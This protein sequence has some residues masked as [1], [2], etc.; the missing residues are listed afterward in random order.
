MSAWLASANAADTDFPL[1][2]LPYGA[3]AAPGGEVHLGVAIGDQIL[4]LRA[5]LA[6]SAFDG[7]PEPLRQACA[8][9]SLNRLMGLGGGLARGLRQRLTQMLRQGSAHAEAASR[10]LVP[11]TGTEMR[12]PV[13]IGDYTDFYASLHH[14]FNVGSLFRPESPLFPNY[15]HVPI[16]YHGRSSSVVVSPEPVRRPWG[17]WLGTKGGGAPPDFAPCRQLDYEVEVG[18]LVGCGN[19]LGEPVRL[20]QAEEHIFGLCL[21]ND[22]SAR[23]IQR[24]EYQPLGPFLGKN[25]ATSVSPWVVPLEALSAFR[26][27]APER[28]PG[29]PALLPDLD[30]P[31]DRRLGGL[32]MMVE[33]CL[34]SRAMREQELE[35]VRLS[36]ATLLDLYWTMGQ[37]LTH[38][39]SNGCNLRPGDLLATGTISGAAPSARGCMLEL[40]RAGKEPLTLPS[41]ESRQFLQ[42]DDEVSLRAYCQGT[43]GVRIGWGECRGRVLPALQ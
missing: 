25:F 39:T 26:T 1:E 34:S 18:F 12:L 21:L 36:R 16:G 32:D 23:D 40:T 17:Q 14:A 33:A 30:D 29:D 31:A 22:W 42:D 15:K 28:A 6:T 24:W 11:Q 19:R 9:P 43:G 35:P 2:N 8:L 37:L 5:A 4:D 38:H 20:A 3:F 13:E 10:L 7:L 27:R 41:G